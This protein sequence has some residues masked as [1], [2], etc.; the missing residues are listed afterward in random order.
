M[1]MTVRREGDFYFYNEVPFTE[2]SVIMSEPG[3]YVPVNCAMVGAVGAMGAVELAMEMEVEVE[4]EVEL[5][6]LVAVLLVVL[7]A[8]AGV[9]AMSGMSA[10]I[11]AALFEF[12]TNIFVP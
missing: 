3:T 6:V 12:A 5:A 11:T 1:Q 4:V 2:V 7:V 9:L 10:A 8:T